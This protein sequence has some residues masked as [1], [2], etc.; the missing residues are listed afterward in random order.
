M[1]NAF[2]STSFLG[3]SDTFG[4]QW[5]FTRINLPLISDLYDKYIDSMILNLPLLSKS[6]NT[7]VTH[8][9]ESRFC[10]FNSTWNKKLNSRD[11]KYIDSKIEDGYHKID[12]TD[13]FIKNTILSSN[14]ASLIIKS[15]YKE[16]SFTVIPTGDSFLNPQI[17]EVKYREQ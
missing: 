10:S 6:T 11:E 12:L 14:P 9:L 13:A 16:K 17:L 4:E 2:G 8:K 1:N 3:H 15:K 7:L 5:L